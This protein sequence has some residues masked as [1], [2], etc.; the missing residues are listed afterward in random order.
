MQFKINKI[1][2]V[3][4]NWCRCQGVWRSSPSPTESHWCISGAYC[5]LLFLGSIII[6]LVFSEFKERLLSRHQDSSW[7]T[8]ASVLVPEKTK[9][10]FC[11]KGTPDNVA[12]SVELITSWWKFLMLSTCMEYM[13]SEAIE[14][15][16]SKV[17]WC[18]NLNS[19]SVRAIKHHVHWL[20]LWLQYNGFSI[21]S[22]IIKEF[23][24]SN[25]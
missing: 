13:H 14:A 12:A 18:L 6:S 19:L 22:F 23:L 17:L 1:R 3:I 11:P 16:W 5:S 10:L 4:T 8:S 2:Q 25:L 9:I 20:L 7:V 15:G 24:M 21:R